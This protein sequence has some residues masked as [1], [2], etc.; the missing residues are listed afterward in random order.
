M[1]DL[2]EEIRNCVHMSVPLS[3]G[4]FISVHLRIEFFCALGTHAVGESCVGPL[5]DI[6]LQKMPLIIR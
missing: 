3:R 6:L 1:P 4:F 5:G 2:L